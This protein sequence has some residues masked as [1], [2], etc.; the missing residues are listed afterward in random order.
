MDDP[1]REWDSRWRERAARPLE[2]DSWLLQVMDLLPDGPV[3][4][5][6]SG[7]GR[8]ALELARRGHPVTAVDL[9][10]EGLDQLR[11]SAAAE[12]LPIRCKQLDLEA[13][14]PPLAEEYAIVLCFF[15]L[16]RPLLPWLM[17]AVR[18]GGVVV[19]RTFSSAGNF[20]PNQVDARF[21]LTPGELLTIFDGWEILWHEEGLEQSRKGGALAGI[22]ARRPERV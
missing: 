14:P 19:L 20:P 15:F 11:A 7:R 17:Q 22:V 12:K 8:N 5:L 9:S 4:D 1:K 6:A 21:V 16:H 13:D 18:P 2:A 3:L 10:G